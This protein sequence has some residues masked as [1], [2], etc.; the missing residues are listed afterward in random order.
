MGLG[1]Q[2]VRKGLKIIIEGM[3][4]DAKGG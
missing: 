2:E 3:I 4:R 1:T